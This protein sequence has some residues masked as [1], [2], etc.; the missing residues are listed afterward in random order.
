MFDLIPTLSR[1]KLTHLDAFCGAGIGEIGAH[2]AGLKTIFAF[3]NNKK[4]V[5]TFNLNFGDIAEVLDARDLLKSSEEEAIAYIRSILPYAD[6]ISGGF[7]CKPWSIV[8]ANE[9]EDNPTSGKLGYVMTLIIK[10]LQPK[11]FLIENVDGLVNSRN[12]DYFKKMV[13]FLEDAGFDV[14]WRVLNSADY[15]VPQKRKRVFIVGFRKDLSIKDYQFPIATTPDDSEK[16][17]IRQAL[18]GLSRS[19]DGINDHEGVGLRNDE[20]PYAHKIP[21]GGN[22]KSL[23]VDEQKAFMKRGFYSGGGRTG[24]LFKVDPDKQAKTIL[25]SPLGK[26]TAQILDW[27]IGEPRRYT[28]R[29]S[30]RLQTVPDTF[31]FADG[32]KLMKK[33][34]RCSGIPSLLS[35]YLFKS[36]RSRIE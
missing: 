19:P 24:A 1:S 13:N 6:V 10:A 27:G 4:A 36:I 7:P 21:N 12:I 30:L 17:T 25:S 35:F 2:R 14:S 5:E 29:E 18:E 32:M 34:E 15:G 28:V 3:D 16:M 11:S 8:G 20:K 33:Y 26:A 9:G 22:W 23:P 31:R